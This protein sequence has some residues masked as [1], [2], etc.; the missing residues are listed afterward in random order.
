MLKD[1][2]STVDK[3]SLLSLRAVVVCK[4]TKTSSRGVADN[5]A[6]TSRCGVSREF[7]AAIP[8]SCN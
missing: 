2:Y 5:S 7:S 6:K 4:G 8:T 3:K 1:G